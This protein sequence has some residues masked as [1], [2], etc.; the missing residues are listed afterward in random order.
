M[1]EILVAYFFP[2]NFGR[3]KNNNLFEILGALLS[4]SV[5]FNTREIEFVEIQIIR[6]PAG[7]QRG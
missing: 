5:L 1:I 7:Y 3:K 6:L 2:C 4:S